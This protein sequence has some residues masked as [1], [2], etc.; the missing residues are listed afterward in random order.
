[1]EL[2]RACVEALKPGGIIVI[3]CFAPAHAR[4]NSRTTHSTG[5]WSRAGPSDPSLLLGHQDLTQEFRSYGMEVL[6]SLQVSRHLKE[7]QFHRGNAYITEFIARKPNRFQSPE[8]EYFKMIK[9]HRAG[10]ITLID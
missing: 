3:E 1:M 5:G 9:H 2:H 6:R 4:V 7:G 8:R 10:V